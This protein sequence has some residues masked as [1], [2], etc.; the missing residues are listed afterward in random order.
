MR[1]RR[2]L[3]RYRRK[4]CRHHR[5]PMVQRAAVNKP[6]ICTCCR[7]GAAASETS[8]SDRLCAH[9]QSRPDRSSAPESLRF[10]YG[11]IFNRTPSPRAGYSRVVCHEANSFAFDLS[12]AVITP[13]PAS[14]FRGNGKRASSISKLDQA[15]IESSRANSFVFFQLGIWCSTFLMCNL[16]FEAL[17]LQSSGLVDSCFLQI[18]TILCS[19]LFETIRHKRVFTLREIQSEMLPKTAIKI[20]N[21][22]GVYR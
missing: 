16:L 21:R 1:C 19:S 12:D 15:E 13:S 9:Q 2:P 20:L 5:L 10:L 8:R 4:E 3:R 18:R 22:P 11:M 14:R 7:F 6:L 17:L